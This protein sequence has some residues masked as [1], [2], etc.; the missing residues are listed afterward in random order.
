MMCLSSSA[1]HAAILSRGLP[2]L[3]SLRLFE[4]ISQRL[5]NA[6]LEFSA[7]WDFREK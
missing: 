2:A 1:D 6:L 5:S 3:C 4:H 7:S